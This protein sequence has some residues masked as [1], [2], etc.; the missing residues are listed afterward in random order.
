MYTWATY[1]LVYTALYSNLSY[2]NCWAHTL[3]PLPT[4][5]LT[6]VLKFSD[7]ENFQVGKYGQ[8]KDEKSRF[9]CKDTFT[10]PQEIWLTIWLASGKAG[11]VKGCL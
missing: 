8:T 9:I 1:L 10:P 4:T 7:F 2:S 11:R 5:T 6:N 3:I